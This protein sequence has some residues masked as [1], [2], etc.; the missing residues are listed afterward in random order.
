MSAKG[1]AILGVAGN[2]MK[3]GVK[4]AMDCSYLLSVTRHGA[5]DLELECGE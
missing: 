3:V 5:F 2:M 4:S 1:V